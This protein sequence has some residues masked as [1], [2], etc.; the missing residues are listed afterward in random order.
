MSGAAESRGM[1]WHQAAW[2]RLIGRIAAG[3][4]PHAVLVHGPR[5]VGKTALAH[6]LG[7]RLLC[8]NPTAD[9]EACDACHG[10]RMRL[11]G[12]HPDLFIA[13]VEKGR[14]RLR[15]DQIRAV[16]EFVTLSSQYGDFRVAVLPDADAMN[17][18]AANALLKTLEE[19][20]ARA[21]LVLVSERPAALPATIRS[22]CHQI[23]VPVPSPEAGAEWLGQHA[24]QAGRLLGLAG[25]APLR[26]MA[27]A[28]AEGGDAYDTVVRQLAAVAAGETTPTAA[29]AHWQG[30]D[31][32]GFVELMQ[33]AVG[34][35]ARRGASGAGRGPD[36]EGL[37]RLAATVDCEAVQAFYRRLSQYRAAAEQPLHGQLMAEALFAEWSAHARDRQWGYH[38]PE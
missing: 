27:L 12:A 17:P 14:S 36:V 22:R 2:Q 23:A 10:C 7:A 16:S 32:A 19:P 9:D 24:P 13:T 8:V 31:R 18:Q 5:G 11:A 33:M 29:A 30:G 37:S 6:R 4:M 38:D 21:V 1:P 15:V 35:I 20:P 34:E 26:A 25:G 28:D 3:T